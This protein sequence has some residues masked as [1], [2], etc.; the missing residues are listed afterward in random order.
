M[1]S[2]LR[3]ACA[4]L[5]ITAGACASLSGG[6]IDLLAQGSAG[7]EERGDANW[8]IADGVLQASAGPG[9]SFLLTRDDYKDF[10][11]N[12]DVYV[13]LEHNSGVFIRCSDR[14]NITTINC[15]EINIFDKRPDQ[16]GR[17]GGVPD[18]FKPLAKVD[19]GGKWTAMKIRAQGP[20]IFVSLDGVTTIDSNGPLL[21]SGPIGLQWGSGEVKFRNV[22]V[23]RL[24]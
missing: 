5:A 7:F 12:L 11:L 10:E 2:A 23:R 8:T 9:V 3:M 13:S 6:S 18:Y 24:G 21:A 20:H 14:A 17:T 16:T 22:K 19:A 4:A 15:Y 1:G